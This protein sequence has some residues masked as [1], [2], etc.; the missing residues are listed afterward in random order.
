VGGEAP[1]GAAWRVGVNSSQV[2]FYLAGSDQADL[3]AYLARFEPFVLLDSDAQHGAPRLLES[4]DDFSNKSLKIL[5]ARPDDVRS[6]EIIKHKNVEYIDV[7]SS[8]VIEFDR[9]YN[10][11]NKLG[12][13]RFYFV[14]RSY[15]R[16][17]LVTKEQSFIDWAKKT[18]ARTRRALSKGPKFFFFYFGKEALRLK[19]SGAEP[20]VL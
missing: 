11:D 10:A 19:E 17:E 20:L 18:V 5:L 15:K 3:L 16:G 13:G 12:R 6:V 4:A 2:N 8:P 9:C 14:L 7:Q 1:A